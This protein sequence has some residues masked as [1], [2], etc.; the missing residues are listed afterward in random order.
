MAYLQQHFLNH[1]DCFFLKQT[2]DRQ[3][4]L[5]FWVLRYPAQCTGLE[6][7]PES[8][9]KKTLLQITSIS[10]YYIFLYFQIICSSAIWKSLFLRNRSYLHRFNILKEADWVI[11]QAS[12]ENI[13]YVPTILMK[14]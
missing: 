9:Q 14:V 12:A 2:T 8:L 10:K 11:F 6:L 3:I 13:C 1:P 4:E 5:Q 7:L